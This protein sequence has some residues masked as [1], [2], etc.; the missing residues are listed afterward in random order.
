MVV[1]LANPCALVQTSDVAAFTASKAWVGVRKVI[2]HYRAGTL[3]YDHL[4]VSPV[5][6]FLAHLYKRNIY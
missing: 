6:L 4:R 1:S 3:S 5:L 2:D